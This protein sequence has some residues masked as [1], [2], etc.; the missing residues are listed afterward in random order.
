M[1]KDKETI[2]SSTLDA[3]LLQHISYIFLYWALELVNQ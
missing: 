3:C 2:R 1:F